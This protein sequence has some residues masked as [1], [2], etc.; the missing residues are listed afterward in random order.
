MLRAFITFR[1]ILFLDRNDL[2][3]HSKKQAARSR[4]CMRI[5]S[6]SK[7]ESSSKSSSYTYSKWQ[8]ELL[9]F[10]QQAVFRSSNWCSKQHQVAASSAAKAVYNN[11]EKCSKQHQQQHEQLRVPTA[12]SSD[13]Q[14]LLL[15]EV[16]VEQQHTN[17]V[18]YAAYRKK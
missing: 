6:G 15:L 11:S 18:L 1:N 7:K 4:H 10:G 9:V 2:K 3:Y 14:L 5:A 16:Y 8:Q 17:A 13:T 12:S